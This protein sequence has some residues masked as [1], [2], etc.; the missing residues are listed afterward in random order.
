LL[1]V[2]LDANT[3]IKTGDIEWDDDIYNEMLEEL[4]KMGL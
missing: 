1:S 3:L 4:E 2:G